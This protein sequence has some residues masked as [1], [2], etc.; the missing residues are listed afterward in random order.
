MPL[1]LKA[2]LRIARFDC[3]KPLDIPAATNVEPLWLGV[4]CFP[5]DAK[6]I[7][8]YTIFMLPISLFTLP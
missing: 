2:A 8:L 5:A 1:R 7:R 6:C 4:F 3:L